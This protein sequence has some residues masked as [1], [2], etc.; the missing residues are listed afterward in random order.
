MLV[1]VAADAET[2]EDRKVNRHQ[3]IEYFPG[4]EHRS[5]D[6][7]PLIILADPPDTPAQATTDLRKSRHFS[8]SCAELSVTA[9]GGQRAR[10]AARE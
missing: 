10:P 1:G 7:M 4:D 5:P 6:S 9:W 8:P 2:A 3:H